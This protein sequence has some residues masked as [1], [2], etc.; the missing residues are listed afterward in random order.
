MDLDDIHCLFIEFET[1]KDHIK[2]EISISCDDEVNMQIAGFVATLCHK[3]EFTDVCG[4]LDNFKTGNITIIDDVPVKVTDV[5]IE[6]IDEFNAQCER[7]E[8]EDM[9]FFDS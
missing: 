4:E 2:G 6:T 5:C 7:I 1:I 8:M 9:M 3:I